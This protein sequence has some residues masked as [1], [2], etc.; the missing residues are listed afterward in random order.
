MVSI[1]DSI[2][3]LLGIDPSDPSFDD[4]VIM[5]INSVFTILTQLG[6]GPKGG[7]LITDNSTEWSEFIGDRK[8]LEVVKT[9]TYLKVRLMFDPPQNSFLVD[10]IK[11]QCDEF[12]WRSNVQI[13][14]P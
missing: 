13:K 10:S 14:T 3:K 12:E 6:I 2:K 7:F 5:D 4:E 8:D 1:L 9:Y 11:K